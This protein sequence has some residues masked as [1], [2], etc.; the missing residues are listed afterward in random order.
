[1]FL[2]FHNFCSL[3]TP[4]QALTCIQM[5]NVRQFNPS[6]GGDSQQVCVTPRCNENVES[7]AH[8]KAVAAAAVVMSPLHAGESFPEKDKVF[9]RASVV[10]QGYGK[11]RGFRETD[12]NNLLY[13]FLQLYLRR[14]KGRILDEILSFFLFVVCDIS[15]M[16]ELDKFSTRGILVFPPAQLHKTIQ[17]LMSLQFL[18]SRL[19]ANLRLS[20][21]NSV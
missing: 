14:T 18:L 6:L 1:M 11:G 15:H 3:Q 17:I 8:I 21:S 4:T 9:P 7:R 13:K 2:D 10:L 19:P 12:D 5:T 20:E 16:T